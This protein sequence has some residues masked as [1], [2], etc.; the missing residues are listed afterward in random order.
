VLVEDTVSH[1]K[2]ARAL[3]MR[4]VWIT[5]YLPGRPAQQQQQHSSAHPVSRR[6][7]R[8]AYVDVKLKSVMGLPG[9]LRS[10]AG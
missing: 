6:A 7:V 5:G 10:L 3:G 9:R 4:T 2:G 1:L 8:P